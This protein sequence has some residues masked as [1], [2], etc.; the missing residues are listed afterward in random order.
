MT[1]AEG[2]IP[3]SQIETVPTSVTVPLWRRK[4][5]WFL[6]ML[7]VLGLIA[8]FT[9][10]SVWRVFDTV[11]TLNKQSTPPPMVS[12]AMLGGSPDT[13]I[14]T[15]PAKTAMAMGDWPTVTDVPSNTPTKSATPTSTATQTRTPVPSATLPNVTAPTSAPTKLPN[16]TAETPTPVPTLTATLP[17]PT[18][19]IT[20]TPMQLSEIDRIKNGSFEAGSEPWYTEN[21][22]AVVGVGDAPDGSS[23]LQ[24]T[25][26][27][28]A[29]QTIFFVPG[30]TYVLTTV[31]RV[32]RKGDWGEV[33]V[34]YL[35]AGGNR[36]KTQEP[37]PITFEHTD[38]R[39]GT[40]TFSPPDGAAKV[41]I[42]A[43]KENSKANTR[44]FFAVDAISVRSVV[45]NQTAD[46]DTTTANQIADGSMTILIMGVDAREGEAID[47]E[48][49]PD[50]LMVIHLDPKADSCRVLSVPRDSRTDLPGY[51][52]TKINHAL[53]VGG[54]DYEVKV[55]STFLDV[56][57]DHYVLVDFNGFEDLVD[58]LGGITVDVPAEFTAVNNM[59][60]EPG[61]QEMNGKQALTYAR[62][63]GDN[64]GDF[65][66]I[67]RQQTIIRALIA[68]TGGLDIVSSFNEFLPAIGGNFRTDLSLEQMID[69]ART[70]RSICGEDAITLLSLDGEIATFQDP[71]L[72]MP[73][74]YVVVDEAEI[75]NKVAELLQR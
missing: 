74:S 42:Y 58:A 9:G 69:M 2:P 4:R 66:R 75:R 21:G 47:G 71:L 38:F 67:Q 33:G 48:V 24:L 59:T 44:G 39:S 35:D 73:L 7:S 45:E 40:I 15:G 22:A 41:Q 63:R 25:T 19:T 6:A 65:G 10:W 64:E 46:S 52:L 68:Q 1:V 55:V 27:G 5:T 11:G 50:S 32:E 16:V 29:N 17:V 13:Q 8:L 54:I 28:Y 56:P 62:H 36:L 43:F 23:V 12:G 51:G 70:Y 26:G 34:V 37:K 30:T 72:N 49:R 18:P 57:I 3:A 61:K 53:A 14:D 60:F 20:P 31:G